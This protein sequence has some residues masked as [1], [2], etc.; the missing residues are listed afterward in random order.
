[1]GDHAWV[2]EKSQHLFVNQAKNGSST[3]SMNQ[4]H[5]HVSIV[6]IGW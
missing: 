2:F 3:M 1:M 4:K 5:S 6:L